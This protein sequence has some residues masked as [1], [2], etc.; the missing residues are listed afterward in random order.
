MEVFLAQC[1]EDVETKAEIIK[2][3]RKIADRVAAVDS[4]VE[5]VRKTNNVSVM[6]L[7]EEYKKKPHATLWEATLLLK[8][9]RVD[10]AV[11]EPV[12]AAVEELDVEAADLEEVAIIK[13]VN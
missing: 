10:V 2:T 9:C 7:E 6:D 5:A 11:E 3:T 13:N 12:A 8:R 4:K 1:K